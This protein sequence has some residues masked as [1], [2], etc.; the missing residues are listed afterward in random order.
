MYRIATPIPE[1]SRHSRD[2]LEETKAALCS[3]GTELFKL[4][5]T[6]IIAKQRGRA[7]RHAKQSSYGAPQSTPSDDQASKNT[8]CVFARETI[9]R[10]FKSIIQS[11]DLNYPGRPAP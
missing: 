10:F 3:T 4:K 5:D 2:S 1:S 8:L 6:S 7:R 9:L 11:E